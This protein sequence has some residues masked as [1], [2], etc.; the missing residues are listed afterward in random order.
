MAI[1]ATGC[2]DYRCSFPPAC[3]TTNYTFV[4]RTIWHR[5]AAL[6][7]RGRPASRDAA[8]MTA[9]GGGHL[10]WLSLPSWRMQR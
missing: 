7:A 2:D 5:Q 10:T 3:G 4:I 1:T 6:A 8:R 9:E